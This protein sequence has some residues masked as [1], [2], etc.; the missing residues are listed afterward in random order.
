MIIR[1]KKL[2]QKEGRKYY[3][4]LNTG[5]HIHI[6]NNHLHENE[7]NLEHE[8]AFRAHW[9][10]EKRFATHSHSNTPIY[11][12]RDR[13][14]NSQT[15]L[16]TGSNVL[17]ITINHND[18]ATRNTFYLMRDLNAAWMQTRRGIRAPDG[19]SGLRGG[20]RIHGRKELVKH[21]RTDVDI[22]KKTM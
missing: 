20:K 9:N 16:Q 1:P 7:Q 22:N 13:E 12:Q 21:W 5:S 15:H 14:N 17:W 3:S 4:K 10:E 6:P 8:N 11:P 18:G 19:E 2:P